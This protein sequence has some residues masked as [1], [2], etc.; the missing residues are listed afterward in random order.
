MTH[1]TVPPASDWHFQLLSIWQPV[2]QLC[3]GTAVCGCLLPGLVECF[4]QQ[5][6]Q[7]CFRGPLTMLAMQCSPAQAKLS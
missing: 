4:E 5:Q 2:L 6:W 1:V 7:Q 3:A